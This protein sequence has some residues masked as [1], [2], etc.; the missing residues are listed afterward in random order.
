LSVLWITG[1]S[2]SGKTTLA[3]AISKELK[4]ISFDHVLLDGDELRE[5]FSTT[6][7]SQNY[8][9]ES[10]ILLALQYSRLCKMLSDQNL[11]VIIATI[12]LF[13]EVQ[14]WNR[15]NIKNYFEVFIDI[16]L[17]ALKSRDSKNI[18]SKFALGEINNVAGLDLPID[19]PTAPDVRIEQFSLQ[20]IKSKAKDIL[21]KFFKEE[22]CLIFSI[23]KRLSSIFFNK[24]VLG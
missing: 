21:S 4:L 2:G 15:S 19:L 18:Y 8:D 22:L 7:S 17:S 1:L 20:E 12:S 13:G 3:Q 24:Y 6:Q 23:K 16:P 14:S 11:M 10:R 9:R 5:I